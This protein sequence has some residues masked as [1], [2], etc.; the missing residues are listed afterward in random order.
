MCPAMSRERIMNDVTNTLVAASLVGGFALANIQEAVDLTS[1]AKIEYV[2]YLLSFVA[3]HA[4]TSDSKRSTNWNCA[5]AEAEYKAIGMHTC[6][7]CALYVI[8]VPYSLPM[9]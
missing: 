9:S 6:C 2:V 8:S 5:T 1:D 3:V 7:C 4:S